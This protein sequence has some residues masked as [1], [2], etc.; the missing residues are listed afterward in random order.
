[1]AS[2]ITKPWVQDVRGMVR[3]KRRLAVEDS[4]NR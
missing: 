3:L 2:N 1:M 4:Q